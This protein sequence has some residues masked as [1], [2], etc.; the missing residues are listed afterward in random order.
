V[1]FKLAAVA[2]RAGE[3]ECS[4]GENDHGAG[5]ELYRGQEDLT[6]GQSCPNRD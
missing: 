1:I 4:V 3:K 5:L 6:R 2:A